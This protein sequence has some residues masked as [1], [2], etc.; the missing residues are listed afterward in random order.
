MRRSPL[1]SFE[2]GVD[3]KGPDECWPWK[4]GRN[5]KGYGYFR[6]NKKFI[7]AHREALKRNGV[8][9]PDELDVLHSCDN[10]PCCNPAH[11]RVGTQ[12]D[13][14]QDMVDRGRTI[15]GRLIHTDESVEQFIVRLGHK[16]ATVKYLSELT[17]VSMATISTYLKRNG[18]V[19]RP[20]GR[21]KKY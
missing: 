4:R 19:V 17:D 14:N 16:G 7:L 9:V 20:R 10:P 11:L 5:K 13:N 15:K 1:V 18:V 3:K 21:P 2:Q 8:D 12:Q 6:R